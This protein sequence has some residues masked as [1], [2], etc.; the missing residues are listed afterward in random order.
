MTNNLKEKIKILT[1]IWG[2]DGELWCVGEGVGE[3]GNVESKLLH[4]LHDFCRS[5]S[6]LLD[7]LPMDPVLRFIQ[8]THR[9][10]NVLGKQRKM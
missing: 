10:N 9:L 6:G 1:D 2:D 8:S 5:S 4:I 3:L 7:H